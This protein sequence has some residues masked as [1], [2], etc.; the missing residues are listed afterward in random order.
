[1]SRLSIRYYSDELNTIKKYYHILSSRTVERD[2]RPQL[3]GKGSGLL[4]SLSHHIIRTWSVKT[5]YFY[6]VI[7][8]G[9]DF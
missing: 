5:E 9:L 1:M 7:G 8:N 3:S 6:S 2:P 4:L